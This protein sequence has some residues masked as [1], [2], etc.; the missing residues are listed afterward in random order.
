MKTTLILAMAAAMAWA[1]APA[2]DPVVLTVGSEKITRS[3]FESIIATLNEQQRAQLEGNPEAKRGLAENL[4]ELKV[5]AQEARAYKLDQTPVFQAQIA[6]QT[7]QALARAVY[8]EM[9]KTAGSEADLRAYYDAHKAEY[10]EAK[11]RHILIRFEGSRVPLREGHKELTDE[12]AL[13]LAKELR[14]KIVA[15]ASFADTAKAESDDAGSG[16]NGGDLGTFSPGEMVP[17][18]DKV[19]FEIPVGT[20]SEPVKSDFGYHL[21]LIEARGAKAF[22]EMRGT[23]EQAVGPEQGAKAVEALKAKATIVYDETYFG[24]APLKPLPPK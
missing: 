5:M 9:T 13:A 18:F 23:I 8:Q 19:A 20:V 17:V 22:E 21:I 11:G 2:A 6:L 24:V 15:G 10:A 12:Q 14:A 3:M 1:Q 4:A 16:A 7:E